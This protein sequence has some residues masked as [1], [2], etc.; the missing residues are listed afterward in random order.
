MG[1]QTFLPGKDRST[2]IYFKLLV[3]SRYLFSIILAYVNVS[4]GF[5]THWYAFGAPFSFYPVSVS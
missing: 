3:K 4:V 5:A 2:A 1:K